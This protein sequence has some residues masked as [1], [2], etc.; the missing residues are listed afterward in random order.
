MGRA[1]KEAME[2]EI[3][4]MP[5]PIEGATVGNKKLQSFQENIDQ[6]S[7]RSVKLPWTADSKDVRERIEQQAVQQY[8][9][10][11]ATTGQFP[12][13]V[14]VVG[15]GSTTPNVGDQVIVNNRS[16]KV[17]KVYPDGTWDPE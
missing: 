5:S 16:M 2:I 14:F 8:N 17:G 7:S 4:N 10:R 9:Q 11:K 15:K 3:A 1:S 12:R 6:M 13:N